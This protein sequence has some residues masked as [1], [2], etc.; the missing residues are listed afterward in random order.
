MGDKF[1]PIKTETSCQLKW[2]WSSLVLATGAT[3]SCHRVNP[4]FIDSTT[5]D[6]FHN[7]PKK[8]SDRELMLAGK[9]PTGGCEYCKNIEDAGG[10]SDRLFH[11]QIPNAFP[12]ELEK[13][14]T[15]TH[16]TPSIIEINFDNLCNMSCLYCWDGSSSKIQQENLKFGRFEKDGV[17][18]D[19]RMTT[20]ADKEKLT[21]SF[22]NWLERNI[23]QIKRFSVLG[24]EPLFQPQ[25]VKCLDFLEKYPCPNLEFSVISNLKIDKKKLTEYLDRIKLLLDKNHIKRFDLTVSI[26]CFGEEQEYVRYGL[27]LNQ[28]KENFQ[29][30]ASHNWI[31]LNFNQTLSV[32]AI[33]KIPELLRF[34][35]TFR[36]NR[37]IG[38]YFG[39]PVRTYKFLHPDIFGSTFFSND[40]DAILSEMPE[41]T[42]Q[43]KEAKKYMNGIRSQ[44][45]QQQRNDE[46][47][48]QLGV[49]LDEIDRRRGVQWRNVFPW[50]DKE[51][52][53]VV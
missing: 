19:N 34:I 38:H 1:F 14:P 46:Q 35:N 22:W 37:E 9:W 21:D 31:Y 25:F 4:E 3:N 50:L 49:Y 17:V 16:V 41:D 15:A 10:Q 48:K 44:I 8:I 27:D 36:Q 43:Q 33:K 23:K 7:L 28:W 5:F 30:V 2:S 45:E 29:L 52:K 6:N 32:L 18:I 26:D 11:L 47:I 24:G 40:F 53:S 42:W 13:D 51:I 39:T 12:I 20:I